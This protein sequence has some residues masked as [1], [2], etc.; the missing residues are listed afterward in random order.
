MSLLENIH[1]PADL[2]ELPPERLGELADEVRERIVDVVSN[3]KGAHFGSNLG[4]VELTIALHRVFQ[5]PRD[6]L[7][8]DVGHQAYPH[9]L[10]TGRN[11]AFPNIRRKGGL[12]GFLRRDESEYDTFGAGHAATSISAACG[13][14]AAR[15]LRGEDFEVIAIIGDGSMTSGLAFEALN[16]AGH[17]ERD[18]IVVLNDNQMSISPNVGAVHKYLTNVRTNPLYHRVREE[19][20]KFIHSAPKFGSLGGMVEQFAVRADDALKAMFVPGMLFEELGFRYVGPVDGHDLEQLVHTFKEVRT[21][22]G[23]RLVHVITTKGKGFAPAEE[24]QV[25][26]HAGGGFDKL[27]GAPLKK[28]SGA[29]LPRYQ[30][31][32]GQALT[33]LGAEYPKV[34]AITA[35]MAEGTSTNLFEKAYP[36]RFFD[37]GIAEGHAVTF[38]AGLATQGIRP[39]V[40]IYSTFLQRAYDSIVHDVAMQDLPV[41]FCMDRAGVAGD[42]GPTHHGAI[43]IPYLLPVP[44]MTI[45]A[46]KDGDEMIGLLRLG[47]EHE[48]GPFGIRWPRDQ[49]PAAPRP[50]AEVPPVEYGTWEVL[51]EGSDVAILATGTMVLPAVEAAAR[52]GGEGDRG[53]GGELPLHQAARR[54]GARAPLPGAP[55]LPDGGGGDVVNGFGAFV[56]AFVGDAGRKRWARRWGS[57]T[58]S[59]RTASAPIC[60]RSWGSP[61]P[62][63]PRARRTRRGAPAPPAA[64]DGLS[65]S[66]SALVSPRRVG[67]VGAPPLRRAGRDALAGLELRE[68]TSWRSRSRRSSLRRTRRDPVLDGAV[69]GPRPPPHPGRR[70]DPAARRAPGRALGVPV[71]GINLGHLGFLTSIGRKEVGEGL[72]AF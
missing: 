20:K 65:A 16:N 36:E 42:D 64:R 54:G 62:G 41:V 52:A 51:R 26:W 17:T 49:V 40:A 6:L 55:A 1:S 71:L 12:S 14:A 45:T 21:M 5:T 48:G 9:K 23:P 34:V 4:T 39:V 2:R 47:I 56:R 68:R 18:L 24:D 43:D 63:S 32:F 11:E 46:P 19:V 22:E 10:L 29:A 67:V 31:V 27:T 15:D 70:R 13:M 57:R 50:A 33:D 53:G 61:P 30:N 37:V 60:W 66:A 25:K 59:S 7:V 38:A 8:W 58:A 35:A 28:A 3:H 69:S 44:G 72:E